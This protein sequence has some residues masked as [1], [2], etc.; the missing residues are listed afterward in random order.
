M[1]PANN[2]FRKDLENRARVNRVGIVEENAT[3]FNAL[4]AEES[5]FQLTFSIAETIRQAR[6]SSVLGSRDSKERID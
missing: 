4:P 6:R 3:D 1:H 5:R 2:V